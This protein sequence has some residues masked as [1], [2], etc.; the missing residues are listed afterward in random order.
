[1]NWGQTGDVMFRRETAGDEVGRVLAV[2]SKRLWQHKNR[3]GESATD[4]SCR[5]GKVGVSTPKPV[6]KTLMVQWLEETTSSSSLLAL[7]EP[8]LPCV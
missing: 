3:G 4:K 6:T 1:M 5:D 7:C 8:M 2:V